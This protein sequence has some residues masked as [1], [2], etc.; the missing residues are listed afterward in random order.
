MSN[1]Y[2]MIRDNAEVAALF[3]KPV[4]AGANVGSEIYPGYPGLVMTTDGLR[5]MAWGF[6]LAMKNKK[7]GLRLKA[8]PVNNAR[9]DKLATAF[10]RDSFT[11][12]RCLIPVTAWA[13]AEGEKGAMTRTWYSLPTPTFSPSRACGA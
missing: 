4:S 6:P 3:G 13:E 1:L 7:T 2:R 5:S 10:W 11:H 9:E 12:R 8:K